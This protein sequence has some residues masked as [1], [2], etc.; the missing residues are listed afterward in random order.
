VKEE[1]ILDVFLVIRRH[2]IVT[3]ARGEYTSGKN[4]KSFVVTRSQKEKKE[5]RQ[6]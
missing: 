3:K 5:N 4:Q 2:G 1:L 6:G